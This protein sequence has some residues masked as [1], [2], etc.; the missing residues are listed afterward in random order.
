MSVKSSRIDRRFFLRATGVNLALPI[1]D[2]LLPGVLGTGLALTARGMAAPS[3]TRPTRMVCIGN[4]FGFYAPSFFPQ[5]A[6]KDYDLPCCWNRSL[7][8]AR[9]SL[10]SQ[11][12][13][14]A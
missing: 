8:I 9:I 10:Y 5:R 7:R 11:V 13:I 14:T 4:G 1:L 12:S 6:G 2:S 3:P